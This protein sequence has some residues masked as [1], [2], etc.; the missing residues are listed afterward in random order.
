M[1]ADGGYTHSGEGRKEIIARPGDRIHSGYA[2]Y[3]A[4]DKFLD[5]RSGGILAQSSYSGT[6]RK[7]EAGTNTQPP[8]S[9]PQGDRIGG[10]CYPVTLRVYSTRPRRQP[11]SE[12][13]GLSS[14]ITELKRRRVFRKAE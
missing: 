9:G 8:S 2:T 4:A 7:Q 11:M 13:S 12:L 6:P 5:Q 3:L 10:F 1:R 14:F